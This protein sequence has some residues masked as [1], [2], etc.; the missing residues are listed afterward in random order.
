MKKILLIIIPAILLLSLAACTAT[1]PIPPEGL[2]I[3]GMSSGIGGD[4]NNYDRQ[5]FSYTVSLQNNQNQDVFIRQITPLISDSNTGRIQTSELDIPV[6]K[7]LSPGEF[8]SASG[9]FRFDAAGLSKEQILELE[10]FVTGFNVSS[11]V[12]LDLPGRH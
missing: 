5:R 12:V 9:E 1:A 3:N 8:M 4:E 6:N 10:P 2:V 7:T 11:S